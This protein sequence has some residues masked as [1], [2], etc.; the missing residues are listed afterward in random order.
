MIASSHAGTERSEVACL[1]SVSVQLPDT[2]EVVRVSF[3]RGTQNEPLPYAFYVEDRELVGSLE[4]HLREHK[5]NGFVR[6]RPQP[7]VFTRGSVVL[8]FLWSEFCRSYAN[9]RQYSVSA[10]LPAAAPLYQVGMR[11][12]EL[13]RQPA[14]Q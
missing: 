13:V 3:M 11:T 1:G 14:M 10:R 5:G 6:M 2:C 4:E 7:H 12:L 9:R 8:Q